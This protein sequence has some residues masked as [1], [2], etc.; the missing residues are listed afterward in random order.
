MA[1]LYCNPCGGT[2]NAGGL[3][4][5]TKHPNDCPLRR[6]AARHAEIQKIAVDPQK[7]T[8]PAQ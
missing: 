4:P 5:H 2:V 6:T 8:P 3:C 7:V 1:E